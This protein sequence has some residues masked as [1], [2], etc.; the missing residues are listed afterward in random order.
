MLNLNYTVI[1]LLIAAMAGILGFGLL[2]GLAATIAKAGFLVFTVLM[3]LFI[4]CDIELKA[5]KTEPS[6]TSRRNACRYF[7][8]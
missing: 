3:L 2:A 1:F 7:I 8:S 6:R 5:T 4:L